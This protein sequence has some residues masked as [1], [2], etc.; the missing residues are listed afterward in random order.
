MILETL[1]TFFGPEFPHYHPTPKR[2][3]KIC[4]ISLSY[5]TLSDFLRLKKQNLYVCGSRGEE[6]TPQTP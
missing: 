6:S 4:K 3:E 5:K 2:D 1:L